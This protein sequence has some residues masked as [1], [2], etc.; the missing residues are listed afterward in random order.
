MERAAGFS[1]NSEI[2]ST[3]FLFYV[4]QQLKKTNW[5]LE[6]SKIGI[7]QEKPDQCN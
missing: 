6:K 1:S 2:C 7:G 4:L 5:N 3:L